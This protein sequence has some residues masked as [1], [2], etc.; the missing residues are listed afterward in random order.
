MLS[1]EDVKR[2]AEAKGKI[3][4]GSQTIWNSRLDLLVRA[5]DLRALLNHLTSPAE[6][7]G[8]NCGCNSGC[9]ALGP[10]GLVSNPAPMT[11]GAVSR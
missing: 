8:D 7:A 11:Q 3:I 5:G 4:E 9:G 6:V 10:G 2:V 1:S